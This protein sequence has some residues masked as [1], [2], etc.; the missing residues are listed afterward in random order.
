MQINIIVVLNLIQAV[1]V[2]V[3]V[4]EWIGIVETVINQLKQLVNHVQIVLV[5]AR[6]I[7]LVKMLLL[8]AKQ[9]SNVGMYR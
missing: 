2:F 5:V 9:I 6:H 4:E 7:I 3:L 8:V 1:V